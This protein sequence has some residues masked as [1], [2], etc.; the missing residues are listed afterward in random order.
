MANPQY[1]SMLATARQRLARHDPADIARR[2]G[3][4]WQDGRFTVSTLGR[5]A[6]SQCRSS[7]HSRRWACGTP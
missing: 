1:E 2:A 5:I 3:V 7:P 4:T 6:P